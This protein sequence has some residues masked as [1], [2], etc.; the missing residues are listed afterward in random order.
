MEGLQVVF[1]V[2]A[3]LYLFAAAAAGVWGVYDTFFR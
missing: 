2:V 3:Y 1:E